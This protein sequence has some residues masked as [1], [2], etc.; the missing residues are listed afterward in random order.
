MPIALRL[1]VAA[2][3]GGDEKPE[4]ADEEIV[5]L[6]RHVLGSR[7]TPHSL[8]SLA[9]NALALLPDEISDCT[10]TDPT[11]FALLSRYIVNCAE[12]PN[13]SRQST[14][15]TLAHSSQMHHSMPPG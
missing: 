7:R 12:L 9:E 11:A 2:S 3:L 13:S 14:P 6:L 1:A 15:W 5:T 8:H 4:L 10:D